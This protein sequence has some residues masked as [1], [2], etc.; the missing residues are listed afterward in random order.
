MA[1]LKATFYASVGTYTSCISDMTVT[2]KDS[3]GS[4]MIIVATMNVDSEGCSQVSNINNMLDTMKGS[5]QEAITSG[6]FTVE[7]KKQ[8]TV[9]QAT[10]LASVSVSDY[11]ITKKSD[12]TGTDNSSNNKKINI[13]LI[14][15]VAV[16]GFIVI[17]GI[18]AFF[19]YNYGRKK[20]YQV[21]VDEK[22]LQ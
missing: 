10:S 20:S 14:I 9:Y 18:I 15:G 22:V 2:L 21:H 1:A 4:A 7:L 16:G 6:N 11:T 8:A 13:G 3:T 19:V 12:T 17:V 5:L